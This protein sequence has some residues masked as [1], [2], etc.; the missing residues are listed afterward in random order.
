M[1]PKKSRRPHP[2]YPLALSAAECGSLKFSR[3]RIGL[4]K[5]LAEAPAE[6]SGAFE[7]T[8]NELLEIG[9]EAETTS[10]I[11]GPEDA[12]RLAAVSKRIEKL[13]TEIGP[14]DR[15]SRA[16]A[17][18]D[19]AEAVYRFRLKLLD[20][21]PP[22]WRRFEVTDCNLGRLHDVVQVVM[23]WHN[24]HLHS[25][26]IGSVYY[27]P[28]Q[29]DDGTFNGLGVLGTDDADEEAVLLSRLVARRGRLRII[30][31]YDFGDS[32]KHEL[33]LQGVSPRKPGVD[34]PRCLAGERACPIED[35]GGVFG[36]R[37][38]L[39][40]HLDPDPEAPPDWRVAEWS[41]EGFDPEAFSVDEV[42]EELAHYRPN[43][44]EDGTRA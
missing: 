24:A 14:T 2:T 32:W 22:I 40:S 4:R 10:L 15:V 36:Y 18:I 30:Y 6:K 28:A 26:K 21:S 5:K 16:A 13:L 3:L 41:L 20:L 34:Y 25:F 23:G 43:P 37:E 12:K 19:P 38:F 29:S 39:A 9:D 7:F 31:E 1:P 42:N 27:G 35:V 8:R 33:I 17:G 11:A 44:S